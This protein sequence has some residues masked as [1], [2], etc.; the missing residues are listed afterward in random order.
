LLGRRL[1]GFTC[2]EDWNFCLDFFVLDLDGNVLVWI[3]LKTDLELG[4]VGKNIFLTLG[5]V[6]GLMAGLGL[7]LVV[8]ENFRGLGVVRGVVGTGEVRRHTRTLF[9]PHFSVPG[10]GCDRGTSLRKL[11]FACFATFFSIFFVC[12]VLFGLPVAYFLRISGPRN[13]LQISSIS[14]WSGSV[15]HRLEIMLVYICVSIIP[16]P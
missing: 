8:I 3:G 1:D 6:F 10:S 14:F 16:P 9:M 2:E 4:L 15:L 5:V 7:G 11:F 13:E 12:F